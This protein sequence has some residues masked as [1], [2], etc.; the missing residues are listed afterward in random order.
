MLKESLKNK[1]ALVTGSGQGIGRDVAFKLADMGVDVIVNDLKIEKNSEIISG[2]RERGLDNP[3]IIT[4]DISDENF[5]ENMF[6][7]IKNKKGKIDFLLNNAGI[8]RD[9]MAKNMD[10]DSFNEVMDVN[11]GGTFLCSKYAFKLMEETSTKGSIV[12]FTSVSGFKGNIG[13][14]NYVASK[15]AVVGLTKT[16]ALE[17]ARAKIRVNCVAPGFIDTPMT[18]VIPQ[19]VKE[20]MISRIPLERMGTGEDIANSV[21]FLISDLSSYITG[22]TI[23]INGGSYMY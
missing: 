22:Q 18:E 19:K 17:Y 13:Q 10:I 6:N 16:L 23:H 11:L 2:L 8:T 15:A 4:G 12:N 5:V 3:L 21:L 7:K 14:V 20:G 1:I 9:N